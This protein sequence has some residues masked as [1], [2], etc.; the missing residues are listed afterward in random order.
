MKEMT[1]K[2]LLRAGLIALCIVLSGVI[3]A[4]AYSYDE[5]NGQKELPTSGY[6]QSGVYY[7]DHDY[8]NC[9]PYTLGFGVKV[10]I[11][12]NGYAMTQ[13]GDNMEGLT[14]NDDKVCFTL[15]GD[16]SE[17]S[18]YGGGTQEH[19]LWL[20]DEDYGPIDLTKIKG[21]A[22]LNYDKGVEIKGKDAIVRMWGV[23]V[24]GSTTSN[25]YADAGNWNITLE[26]C[27]LAYVWGDSS[28]RL[29]DSVNKDAEYSTLTLKDCEVHHN[30]GLSDGGGIFGKGKSMRILLRE[31]TNIHD[32]SSE[33]DGGGVYLKGES[34]VFSAI[35]TTIENNIADDNGGGVYVDAGTA[36]Y[37]FIHFNDCDIEGNYTVSG[38]GGGLYYTAHH[39][40]HFDWGDIYCPDIWEAR[41]TN[42]TA[43]GEGGAVYLDCN[44]SIFRSCAFSGNEAKGDGGAVYYDGEINMS[45]A[46]FLQFYD[47]SFD[48]NKAINGGAIYSD[49][50]E[51]KLYRCNVVDNRAEEYGGGI[52]YDDTDYNLLKDT[53]IKG[54]YAG[55]DYPSGNGAY[56]D[57]SELCLEGVNVIAENSNTADGDSWS[58]LCVYGSSTVDFKNGAA[59]EDSEVW[60]GTEEA[61]EMDMDGGNP[62]GRRVPC[63]DSMES[64]DYI[65]SD[66]YGYKF[67][68]QGGKLAYKRGVESG[69]LDYEK[70][71]AAQYVPPAANAPEPVPEFVKPI[72]TEGL[73]FDGAG[74]ALEG[75]LPGAEGEEGAKGEEGDLPGAE[76]E[77]GAKGE[78]G[79]LPG[80]E[81]EGGTEGEEGDL[82]GAEGE[83]GTEGEE[84]D[85]PGAEGEGGTEGG[86][87]DPEAGGEDGADDTA[88]IFGKLTGVAV[89]VVGGLALAAVYFAKFKKE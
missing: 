22:I 60:L 48:G 81:G 9:G 23:A 85:L 30:R 20:M 68:I 19:Q 65:F 39:A 4:S 24:C 69:G 71:P 62:V 43:A 25:I 6:L 56:L 47:T 41:F 64:A 73:G 61:A 12:M 29:Y 33:G 70:I 87:G 77:E 15:L 34:A 72:E 75:D 74:L 28:I 57:D 59:E 42:N 3:S 14:Y 21:S 13:V 36:Y 67:E 7:M 31:G 84:G 54:N 55:A 66:V 8:V 11:N 32:N 46:D 49:A 80:A 51:L 40:R 26:D 76:G 10:I 17:L 63:K 45:E 52:Y 50:D 78:D 35:G 38:D 2:N 27:E 44:T 53:T 1:R 88:S 16:R 79:D 82:P 37:D 58:N 83:G 89:I 18:L 5:G 86:E